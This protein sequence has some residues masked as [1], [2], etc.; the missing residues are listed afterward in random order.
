[1][2][3]LELM[4]E[5]LICLDLKATNKKEVIQEMVMMLKDQDRITSVRRFQKAVLAREKQ[6]STGIGMGVGIPHAKSSAV[7]KPSVAFAV[8]KA[9]ID[10]DAQ[11]GAP[12]TV[13]FLIAIPEGGDDEHLKLLSRISRL[14]VKE[15]F[16]DLL[17]ESETPK[18]VLDHI[19]EGLQ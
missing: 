5:D 17:K 18:E 19:S 14:L 16:V 11:D 8:S 10:F 6:F 3:L 1:M 9:G 2:G 7:K 13:F 12:V 4:G 15:G